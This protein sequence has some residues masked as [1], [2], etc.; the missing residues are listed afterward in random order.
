MRPVILAVDLGTTTLKGVL[1]DETGATIDR[2]SMSPHRPRVAEWFA[3][4][5][6]VVEHLRTRN[7]GVAIRAISV[8]GQM[9]GT[10]FY[11]QDEHPIGDCLLWTNRDAVHLL[12]D[13]LAR[14]GP[15]LPLR[16]G[17]TIAPGYQALNLYA[18]TGWDD[19]S[20]VLLPKDTLIHELTGRFVTDPSDAAGTGLFDGG[21]GA[22]AADIVAALGIPISVLPEVVASGSIVGNLTETAAGRLHLGT[23]VPVIIA[24]GDTPV[25]ALGAG[26]FEPGHYQFMLSTSAQVLNPTDAWRPHPTAKW[27]TW[28]A[29]KAPEMPGAHWL[30]SGTM[31]NGGAVIDWLASIQ[32]SVHQARLRP[33]P[34][35]A[36]PHLAGRRFPAADPKASGA[37]IGL[38]S[39]TN[40]ADLYAAMLQGIAFS[41]REVFEALSANQP[42]PTRV[43]FGGGGSQIPG[44]AQLLADVL[45]IGIEL[46]GG[47]DL[48]CDGAAILAA[49]T[50]GW[51]PKHPAHGKAITPDPEL[52]KAFSRIY[53][54]YLDA[55]ASVLPISHRLGELA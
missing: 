3:S 18:R 49:H 23:D 20:H 19:I 48:T 41:Y 36:L 13:L 44:V 30:R 15:D 25:A 32:G 55:N 43:R 37:F 2:E 12:P 9:H 38:K 34:L 28:P 39:S 7:A 45:G 31:S 17:S 16:I 11:D 10:Q 4:L 35:I 26:T 21:A 1:V 14:V 46:I 6:S 50:L 5:V 22:W 27:Y 54:I 51:T 53:E 40:K 52:H 33:V 42:A 8:T 24:G 29:A 47:S